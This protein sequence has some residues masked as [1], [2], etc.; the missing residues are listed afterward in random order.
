MTTEPP[1]KGPTAGQRLKEDASLTARVGIEV[2]VASVPLIGGQ[3]ATAITALEM[4]AL[5]KRLE[6]FVQQLR[7]LGARIDEL[8]VDRDYLDSPE[9][10]DSVMAAIDAA[11]RT[12][13]RQKLRMIAALLLGASTVDRPADLDVEAVLIALRDLSP[14]ALWMAGKI[15]ELS[16][17]P[18]KSQHMYGR[19]V[20]PAAPDR[21]FLLNRL[22]AAGLI[23]QVGSGR[24]QAFQGDFSPTDTLSRTI[25]TMRAGGWTPEPT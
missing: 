11:R 18:G 3:L 24:F 20:P 6:M 23:N 14:M 17:E 13:D 7:D 19:A 10:V 22:V 21:D 8:K 4:H 12:S 15:D 9:F 2:A 16:T 5:S 1:L 25:R